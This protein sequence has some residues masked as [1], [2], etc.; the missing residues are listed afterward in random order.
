M[1]EIISF[2]KEPAPPEF[3]SIAQIIQYVEQNIGEVTAP[4]ILALV[5]TLADRLLQRKEGET[6]VG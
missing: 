3:T 6:D 2:P 5:N 1:T 4:Q